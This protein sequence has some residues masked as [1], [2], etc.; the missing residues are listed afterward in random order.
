MRNTQQ[1]YLIKHTIIQSG[2]RNCDGQ[3]RSFIVRAAN[4]EDARNKGYEK[5]VHSFSTAAYG[6]PGC[7]VVV[8]NADTGEQVFP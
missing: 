2:P 6:G 8:E 1:R 4:P 3:I 5:F 7:H